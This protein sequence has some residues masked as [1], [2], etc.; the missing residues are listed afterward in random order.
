MSPTTVTGSN[1]AEDHDLLSAGVHILLPV[2]PFRSG[3]ILASIEHVTLIQQT[4][5]STARWK[6]KAYILSKFDSTKEIR[7]ATK[8]SPFVFS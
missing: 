7:K 1:A 5:S 2:L 6:R 4:L 3:S 8:R